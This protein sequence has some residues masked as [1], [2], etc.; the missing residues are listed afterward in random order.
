MAQR[1]H[2]FWSGVTLTATLL[3]ILGVAVAIHRLEIPASRVTDPVLQ[4]SAP[5]VTLRGASV[6]LTDSYQPRGRTASLEELRAD[7]IN[8][9]R[10]A[11]RIEVGVHINNNFQLD[12]DIPAYSSNGTLWL[13]WT[14]ALQ[15]QLAARNL[16]VQDL[17]VLANLMDDQTRGALRPAMPEPQKLADGRLLQQFTFTG[18]FKIDRLDLHRFPFNSLALPLILE[19]DDPGGVFNFNNLRLLPD[20]EDSGLGQFKDISGWINEGWSLAEFRHRVRSDFG[21]GSDSR[22]VDHSQVVFESVYRT[23]TWASFWKL[24]QP[25][26][27]VLAMTVLI[28]KIDRRQWDL[29]AGAPITILLTLVFLQQGYKADLPPLP[30]LTF[31]DRLYVFAYL[32]ALTS[33]IFGLWSCRR[34]TVLRELPEGPERHREDARLDRLDQLFPTL[35]IFS[36]VAVVA[37]AWMMP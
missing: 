2:R 20:T 13:K 15:Q 29:R 31:L 23:S 35:L 3:A 27:V 10:V 8:L 26:S 24:L 21:E 18:K 33:F 34:E 5:T 19:A 12:F 16:Q 14:P 7:Q 28:P 9:S 37:L 36:G 32:T 4:T 1:K 11:N 6:L 30:Y 17:L 25:M 22:S